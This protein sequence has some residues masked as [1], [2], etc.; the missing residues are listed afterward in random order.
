MDEE[1]EFATLLRAPDGQYLHAGSEI[2]IGMSWA[3]SFARRCMEQGAI[4]LG[5]EGFEADGLNV[6]PR[7]DLIADLGSIVGEREHRL[8]ESGKEA[9]RLLHEWSQT[10][11]FVGFTLEWPAPGIE[12]PRS[13]GRPSLNAADP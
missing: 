12:A 6:R 4:I 1:E 10:P 2:L 11:I 8:R 5:L 9:V 3:E 13:A 7:M